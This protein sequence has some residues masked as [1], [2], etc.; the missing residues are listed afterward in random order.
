[1]Q[2]VACT[3]ELRCRDGR[4]SI[5]PRLCSMVICSVLMPTDL[6][7]A[8]FCYTDADWCGVMSFRASNIS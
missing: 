8:E 2:I 5:E 1:M 6:Y 3:C 4:S 7:F